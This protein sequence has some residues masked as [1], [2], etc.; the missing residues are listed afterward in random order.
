[1]KRG[2]RALDG[3][4]EEIRDHIARQTEEH[5]AR[6]MPPG[7]A[8]RQALLDFGS[9][10]LV[11]EDTRAVWAAVRFEQLLQDARY[12]L[13]MFRR[14]PMFSAIAVLTLAL[15]VGANTAM[16][17]IVNATVL[18]PVPFPDPERLMTVWKGPVNDPAA[19][20]ITSLPNY[21]DWRERTHVF[22]ELA[23]FDSI[24]R[25]YSLTGGG[26]P[27]Q[28]SGVRVTASFFRVLGVA[29]LLGRTFTP[30]EEEPGHD[31]V[32][33]LSHGLWRRRFAGDASAVGRTL[34]IDGRAHTVVGVMPAHFRFQFSSAP[35]EL[36]VPAGWTRNDL[37][38]GS[39]SF[40]CIGRLAPEVG[41]GEAR[42]AMDTIGR[43]LAEEYPAANAGQTVRV[44][45]MNDYSVRSTRGVL[46]TLLAVV[47][48]VLLIACVNVANLMLARAASRHR[49]LAVKSALGA[50]RSR[51]ARQLLT[52]SIMLACLGGLAG[53]LLAWT[54]LRALLSVGGLA[55]ILRPLV[56]VPLRSLE[57][58]PLDG[59]VLVFTLAISILT[60]VLF[61]AA[62]AASVRRDLNEPLREGARG[63]A[64]GRYGRLRYALVASQIALTLITLAGAGALIVSMV[65]LLGVDPGFEPG[66]VLVMEMSL[67]QSDL[68]VGPPDHPG[69]CQ[70]L[71][72][73][74]GS[75][76]GV[77]SVSGI[78][79]LPLGGF[80]AG[81]AIA[82]EG[83]PDP[84]PQNQAGA[85]YTVACPGILRTLG[86]PLLEGREF[87]LRDTTESLPVAIVNETMARRY[88]PGEAVVGR[89]FKIGTFNSAGQW[90]QIVGVFKDIRSGG[91]DNEPD[92]LF[93]RPYSQAGWPSFTV[94]VKSAAAPRSLARPVQ[95]ALAVTE[96]LQPVTRV[97]TMEDVVG[98]SVSSRRVPMLLM[99]AFAFLALGLAAVGI[100]GVVGYSVTQR[101]KEIAIRMALGSPP[102]SVLRLLI[103]DSV[104]WALAGVGLGLVAS[105]GL[106]GFLRT[107]VYDVTPHDPIVLGSVSLVLIGVA[108]LATYLPA[109]RALR[110]D[111]VTTLRRD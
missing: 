18:R 40:V 33:V 87:T 81:R 52:E 69:F 30:E 20:N 3:F 111:P 68:Y 11:Q 62:P 93:V 59:S 35:L 39:N 19:L 42:A 96:P 91:L 101:A 97:R 73:H 61:G 13:R 14:N 107:L 53:L 28:V 17:S 9:I 78:A 37:D 98:L 92:P 2:K 38:R 15:G 36:W 29:P 6:G 55:P 26:E 10:T 34:E 95:D 54:L 66:N 83:R 7:E 110:I 80:R 50:T 5:I 65:R 106:L 22:T 108:L 25:G 58:I 76:P 43:G 1:M 8:R 4:D 94:V 56:A 79:H 44:V 100:S 64:A 51:L 72:D 84:G 82:V 48:F 46:L 103:R 23:L 12:A 70:S 31:A 63:S 90:L 88:W 105:V 45:P 47:A 24:G 102:R 27:E 77:V 21:R 99:T 109:R 71:Q 60:G 57:G 74:A 104:R 49:E 89:R 32:V 41:V 75:V 16:F 85:G 86:I 67:P